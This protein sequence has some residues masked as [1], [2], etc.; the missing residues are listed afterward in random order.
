MEV[1][2]AS[3]SY[4]IIYSQAKDLKT[5]QYYVFDTN[6]SNYT[7][8]S[9]LNLLTHTF[10]LKELVR[11]FLV[12]LSKLVLD[13]GQSLILG[14]SVFQGNGCMCKSVTFI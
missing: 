7:T 1:W 3:S 5:F 8:F 10:A 14:V 12:N 11:T 2:M 13:L 9:Y 6:G 4:Y